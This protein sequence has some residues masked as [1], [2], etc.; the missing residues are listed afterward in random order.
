MN[1][2]KLCEIFYYTNANFISVNNKHNYVLDTL[3]MFIK[4]KN[5]CPSLFINGF[6]F[7]FNIFSIYY[8]NVIK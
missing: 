5:I 3:K 1:N 6:I 4:N 2:I 8:I 7:T